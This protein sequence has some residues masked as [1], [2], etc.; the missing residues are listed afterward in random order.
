[1]RSKQSF[2]TMHEKRDRKCT[3][4]AKSSNFDV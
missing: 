3:Q 1:M 4:S 2:D